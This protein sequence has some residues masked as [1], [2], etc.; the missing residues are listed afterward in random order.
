MVRPGLSG[1]PRQRPMLFVGN[2]QTYAL[3]I[4]PMVEAIIKECDIL[5]RGL[6]HPAIWAVCCCHLQSMLLGQGNRINSVIGVPLSSNPNQSMSMNFIRR[7]SISRDVAGQQSK[8][9]TTLD[10]SACDV[11]SYWQRLPTVL[12]KNGSIDDPMLL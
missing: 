12:A 4:G 1:V 5:P 8:S 2:H 6:A 3:D 10:L 9:K 7:T 11:V